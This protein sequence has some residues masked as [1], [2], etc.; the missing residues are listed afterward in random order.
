MAVRAVIGS[1]LAPA[2]PEFPPLA[3]GPERRMLRIELVIL[4]TVTFGIQ[5][6]R[7]LLELIDDLM[8]PVA[9]GDQ[10][11]AINQP[12]ASVSVIDL[13]TQ[14]TSVAV[15]VAWGALALFLLARTGIRPAMV[16][17]DRNRLGRD[18]AWGAGLA[19]VIGIPGLLLYLAA[20]TLNLSKK[21]AP[22]TLVD[23]W[24]TGAVLILLAVANAVAEESVVVAFV[25]T[26]L[27][28]FGMHENASLVSAAV[29]RGSYHLYQGW[30]AFVGNA[31]MG[32][33]LGRIWQRTNRLW[34]LVVTHAL[35]DIVA[36][37]GYQVL[38]GHVSW[39]PAN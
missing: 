7:S 23:S 25:I 22:S 19:A 28:Q 38:H 2:R 26:R 4:L 9:L 13:L 21:V 17:M 5:G 30:S 39:L 31:L 15:L 29:L 10:S 12:Q 18:T 36:F 3:D 1:W 14:L 11:V 8:S 16:G 6:I 24:W 37:L 32:L 35:L 33:L 27:R 34:A 20:V